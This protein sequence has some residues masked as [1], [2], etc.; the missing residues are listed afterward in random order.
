MPRLREPDGYLLT[1]LLWYVAVVAIMTVY[2]G[3]D[4]FLASAFFLAAGF[5]FGR[6]SV[7]R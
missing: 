2:L 1:L 5:Y 3:W 6:S 7:H 4:G